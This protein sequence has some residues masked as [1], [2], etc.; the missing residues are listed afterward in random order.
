MR[1][2]VVWACLMPGIGCSWPRLGQPSHPFRIEPQLLPGDQIHVRL[3][4]DVQ[5]TVAG[6]SSAGRVSERRE[7]QYVERYRDRVSAVRDG[8]PTTVLR[9]W[10]LAERVTKDE[11][12][13][14]VQRR[15]WAGLTVKAVRAPGADTYQLFRM[16]STGSESKWTPA[17]TDLSQRVGERIRDD[18][19]LAYFAPEEPVRVGQAWSARA[20]RF[21]TRDKLSVVSGSGTLRE[22]VQPVCRLERA[23]GTLLTVSMQADGQ[24]PA[25]R[26]PRARVSYSLEATI[27]YDTITQKMAEFRGHMRIW[28]QSQSPSGGR[29]ASLK[30]ETA[31]TY[32]IEYRHS[33][34]P[35]AK[36]SGRP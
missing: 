12:R 27:L 11:Q 13:V 30:N 3:Q 33:R 6:H 9:H 24:V 36:P 20:P 31:S 29:M 2:A 22:Y 32:H 26:S 14:A 28:V 18:L 10:S 16:T 4:A 25:D 34:I 21:V 23:D 8:E 15:A 19:D 35:P 1:L 5:A 17:E 7:F